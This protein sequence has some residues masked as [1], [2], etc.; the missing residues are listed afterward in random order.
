MSDRSYIVVSFVILSVAKD[1]A[2]WVTMFDLE[3]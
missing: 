3:M 2:G 1:L